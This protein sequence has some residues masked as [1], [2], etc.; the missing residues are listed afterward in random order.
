MDTI[1]VSLDVRIGVDTVEYEVEVPVETEVH[2]F[3]PEEKPTFDSPG[4]TASVEWTLRTSEAI[5][6][7][8]VEVLAS[9]TEVSV[10]PIKRAEIEDKLIRDAREQAAVSRAGY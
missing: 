2:S 5:F 7:N 1:E 10:H 3:T 4:E 6:V 9:G 8:G